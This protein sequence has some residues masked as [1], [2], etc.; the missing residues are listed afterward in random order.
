[1]TRLSH[2][3]QIIAEKTVCVLLV[4]GENSEGQRIYAYVGVRA[5]KLKEFMDAQR[6]GLFY[7]ENYGVVIESGEGEPTEEIREKMT[8]EYGFNHEA[9]ID[10][11]DAL[12]AEEITTDLSK[13]RPKTPEE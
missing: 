11:P 7:P 3:E 2:S 5:D 1:M 6:K 12:K 9:M 8:R 13:R 4:R 10:I